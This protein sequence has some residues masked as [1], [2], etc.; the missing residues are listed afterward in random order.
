VQGGL[1][2]NACS[3]GQAAVNER[4]RVRARVRV[5]LARNR[6]ARQRLVKASAGRT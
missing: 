3:A 4:K 5:R 6:A 1:L 2:G